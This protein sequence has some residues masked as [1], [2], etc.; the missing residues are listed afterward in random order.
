[1]LQLPSIWVVDDDPRVRFACS[2]LLA[3]AGYEVVEFEDGLQM[4]QRLRTETPA[5]LMLD[6]EMPRLDGWQTLAEVRQSGVAVPVLMFTLAADVDSKVRGL[7]AGADDYVSKTGD[8]RELLARV[9]ALLRRAGQKT[10]RVSRI[11][12]RDVEINLTTKTATRGGKTLKLTRT[13]YG[14]LALLHRK[15]GTPVS[16]DEILATVWE[17]RA[18]NSHALDTHLWRLRKKIGDTETERPLIRNVPGIGYVLGPGET[19]G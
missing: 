1:M 10:E 17:S 6:V 2:R 11:R 16:R 4:L 5:L 14:L 19:S 18:G 13:D 12:F 3:S 15:A 8:P 7:G 9:A